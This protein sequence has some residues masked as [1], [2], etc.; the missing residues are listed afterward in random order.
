MPLGCGKIVYTF[1]YITSLKIRFFFLS[2]TDEGEVI[3]GC[4]SRT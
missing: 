3:D 2:A 1:F 4:R